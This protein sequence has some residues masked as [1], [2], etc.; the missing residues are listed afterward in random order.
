MAGCLPMLIQMPVMISLFST[1]GEGF[2]LRHAPFISWIQDLSSPDAL[3]L[4]PFDIPFLGNG[5]GTMNFNLLVILYIIT[6]L[7]QQSMMP[8]ST[9]PQQQ[10]TQKMMKF[11]MVGFAVILYNY[12]SGLMLYFVGSNCLGMAESWY[13]RNRILPAM[14]KK[15]QAKA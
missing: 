2:A 5:D 14:E 8:K 15:R 7:I 10:Q 4:M 6:M 9:D 3:F 13:I 1:V 12:S 11:M